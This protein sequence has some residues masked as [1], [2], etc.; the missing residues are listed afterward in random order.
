M[1]FL[2]IFLHFLCCNYDI[3]HTN[4][5]SY[6]L[7]KPSFSESDVNMSKFSVEFLAVGAR[8]PQFYFL[9][10]FSKSKTLRE[11][12]VLFF[13]NSWPKSFSWQN[14]KK[15]VIS[16]L[17]INSRYLQ[18][19]GLNNT[20]N[21]YL[22]A[23]YTILQVKFVNGNINHHALWNRNRRNTIC[24]IW[25][26]VRISGTSECI[27]NHWTT[28]CMYQSKRIKRH[29]FCIS[30]NSLFRYLYLLDYLFS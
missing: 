24:I 7:T 28:P 27:F 20:L 4:K 1:Q 23:R 14:M 2:A 9:L 8:K 26:I 22:L 5:R 29:S 19:P 6:W 10:D 16:V 18:S 15:S 17:K 30:C 11:V 3:K 13:E 25:V 12:L 21:Q